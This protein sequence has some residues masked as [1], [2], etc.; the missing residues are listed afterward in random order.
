MMDGSTQE[1]SEAYLE[2]VLD[3]KSSYHS[4]FAD[5]K[6][7]SEISQGDRE[8]DG[9]KAP[10][11]VKKIQSVEASGTSDKGKGEFDQLGLTDEVVSGEKRQVKTVANPLFQCGN[12]EVRET[13]SHLPDSKTIAHE[14]LLSEVVRLVAA[15]VVTK[16]GETVSAVPMDESVGIEITYDVLKSGKP[17][18]PAI[19]LIA[20]DGTHVFWAVDTD[21]EPITHI[22]PVGVHVSTAWMPTHFLNNGRYS[23]SLSIFTPDPMERHVVRERALSFYSLEA[24]NDTKAARGPIARDFPGVLRP[25]LAWETYVLSEEAERRRQQTIAKF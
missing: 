24:N 19:G 17:L 5:L 20:P 7:S 18:V 6:E 3:I 15:R 1:V 8:K 12:K 16:S 25:R 4:D 2:A 13:G 21:P 9:Q 10:P 14:S 22:K 11:I 23:V